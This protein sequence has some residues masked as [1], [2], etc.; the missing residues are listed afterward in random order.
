MDTTEERSWLTVKEFMEQH[1]LGKNLV[2]DAVREGRLRS[3][4]VMGKILIASDALDLLSEADA[5]ESDK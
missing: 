4:R 3:C 5:H 2:Y 1:R